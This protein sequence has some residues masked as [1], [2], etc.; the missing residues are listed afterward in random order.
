M[1]SAS[2]I[3]I[4]FC[5]VLALSLTAP[6][7]LGQSLSDYVKQRPAPAW[8]IEQEVPLGQTSLTPDGSKFYRLVDWQQRISKSANDRY[9]HNAIELK[10]ADAVQDNSNF[11]IAFDP[12]YQKVQIHNLDLIRNGKRLGRLDLSA[13]DMYR[14]E[15]DRDKLLYNG[16]METAL[17]I[18]DVQVGDI[19]DYSYSI[20]G[21]N[22]AIGPH[23]ATTATLQYSVPIQRQHERILIHNDT[24]VHVKTHGSPAPPEER[25]EGDYRSYSWVQTDLEDMDIES[26]LPAWFY[27]Q[28]TYEFSSFETW[29]AV[30][31]YFAN[32]YNFKYKKGGP[33]SNIANK[34]MHE[35]DDI[36]TRQR[37]ALNYIHKNIRY[38]GIKMDSGGYIPRPPDKTLAQKFGDCKDMT[39]LLLAILQEMDIEAYPVFVDSDYRGG[40]GDMI[41]SHRAFDHVLVHM[42]TGDGVYLLDGT[43]GS[44]LGDMDRIEQGSYGKGLLLKPGDARLVNLELKQPAYYKDVQDTFDFSDPEHVT[45]ESISTYHGYE[46]D[47]MNS[48][49]L[50]NGLKQLEENFLSF[51]QNTYPNLEQIGD[52]VIQ[53]EP[54]KGKLAIKVEYDLGKGWIENTKEQYK[55]FEAYPSDVTTDIPDFK[56]GSRAMPYSLSHPRKSRHKLIFKLDETWDLENDDVNVENEAFKFR[57]ISTFKNGTYIQNYIYHSKQDHIPAGLFSDAMADIKQIEEEYGVELTHGTDWLSNIPEETYTIAIGF[58][59]IVAALISMIGAMIRNNADSE[60]QKDQLFYPVALPKFIILSAVSIGIYNYF[61]AYKNWRWIR[62]IDNEHNTPIIR[63]WF[64]PFTNFAL[65]PQLTSRDDSNEGYSWYGPAIGGLIALVFF[66]LKIGAHIGDRI[67]SAPLWLS[68]LGLLAFIVLIPAVMQINRLN[69]G[70]EDVIAK[71]SAY[72]WTTIVFILIFAPI[73]ILVMIGLFFS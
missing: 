1:R 66:G 41:P 70:R 43:R 50:N 18:P 71:N 47:S 35:S 27:A 57:K 58:W 23:Y 62:D 69:I 51:F 32:A 60:W 11:K 17:I 54:T 4:F 73:F 72:H 22:K 49:Y 26:N 68:G 3:W 19:L 40:I 56:G 15:T 61:W 16:T 67:D 5:T 13:F 7:A 25:Q 64:M 2:N 55:W 63:G 9:R 20:S 12:S 6:Q 44:Q 28:P 31:E 46:A 30:G 52:M 33:I 21:K 14:Q 39:L 59:L 34:I 10:T 45:L 53:I 29:E 48:T 42:E 65:L 37:L 8:V 36:K 38:T 24:P